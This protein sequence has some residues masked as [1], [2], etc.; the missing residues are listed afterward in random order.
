[1]YFLDTNICIYY[2]KGKYKSIEEQFRF[3]PRYEIKIPII[4]KAELLYGI[5][6]SKLKE[7]NRRVYTEFIESFEIINLDDKSLSQYAK[8]RSEVEKAGTII[9]SNDLFIASIVLAHNGILVTHNTNE[10]KRI[11]G[12]N[13]EDWVE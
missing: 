12:L 13:V 5:E 4:V 2:L 9:G 1:M 8:I 11:Y 6:K 10:F 3:V 7:E